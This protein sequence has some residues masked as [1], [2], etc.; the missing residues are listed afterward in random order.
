MEF[1]EN[2]KKYHDNYNEN[3]FW[4]K[5]KAFAR[6][7]GIKLIYLALLL[8]YTL[9]SGNLS[10]KDKAI[11]YGALGYFILPIDLIPDWIPVIGLS[12]DF[13]TLMYAYKRI[14]ENITD[15]IREKAEIKLMEIFGNFDKAEIE[16]L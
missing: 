8:F 9:Q 1:E 16:G 7:A 11:I 2:T 15:E 14:K 3:S 10:L 12:D 4:D 6:K 13:G 5:I